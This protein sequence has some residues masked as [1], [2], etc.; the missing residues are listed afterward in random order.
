MNP[1][2]LA[3]WVAAVLLVSL[4]SGDPAVRALTL[5]AALAVVLT[6]RRPD[7]RVRPALSGTDYFNPSHL[8]NDIGWYLFAGAGGRAVAHNIFLDGN[9]FR[10]SPSVEHKTFV[11]DMQGGA[12]IFWSDRIRLDL[13]AVRRTDEFV[14]QRAPDVIGTA[15]VSF[16]W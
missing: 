10:R 16:S 15:A 2:A 5:A 6:R 8:G 3:A 13:S 9:S 4:A 11:A 12:S 1:R 14:G 7:V